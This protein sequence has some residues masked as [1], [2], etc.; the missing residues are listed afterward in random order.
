LPSSATNKR[1]PAERFGALS[2]YGSEALGIQDLVRI[3]PSL[4]ERLDA[5]LPY[6]QAEEVWGTRIEMARTVEDILARRFRALF[7]NAAS[8]S[9]MAPAV[10]QIMAR[11]LGRDQAWQRDQ[12]A[13]F[14]CLADQYRV[15][16]A[17]NGV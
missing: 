1:W 13:A 7:L 10:A 6:T 15:E 4:S 9:R 17:Q 8:A 2:V 12:I 16:V 14:R 5:A 11:E 3:D